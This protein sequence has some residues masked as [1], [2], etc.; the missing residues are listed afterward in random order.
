MP[1]FPD[2]HNLSPASARLC[3]CVER[4]L[5]TLG[6]KRG[7][8]L[9]AAVSGGSDSTAL[10]FVLCL[11]AQ[12]LDLRI[13]ALTVDHGLLPEAG[14]V[15][16]RV[17]A[18]CA[19]FG[20][21]CVSRKVDVLGL[22]GREHLGIEEAGRKLRYELLEDERAAREAEY[23]VLG[24]H[25]GDLAEDVLM[26]LTRGAGWPAL[27]GMKARDDRRRL[28]RPLLFV[29]PRDL[30]ALL[31]ECGLDWFEDPGNADLRF[32][33]NR[34]RHTVL[35]L[36]LKE[37]PSLDKKIGELWRLAQIDGDYWEE[38]L[39][40]LL[41]KHPWRMDAC[42]LTLPREL[43]RGRHPA[44]R[45]RLY[46]RALSI[47]SRVSITGRRRQARAD[48]LLA[49]DAAL[50]KGRGNARFQLPGG[51][52]AHLAGGAVVFYLKTAKG[53]DCHAHFAG[54]Q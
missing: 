13:F 51:V 27:G 53:M 6:L 54:S 25:S 24:H 48:T 47:F 35:P 2:I 11:L 34:L 52:E 43:L 40:E 42:C 46:H 1:F 9:L 44:V 10:V 49:L 26:R 5:L 14:A 36:L 3:L 7:T 33:R 39:D 45:L 16:A 23:S 50:A 12:R 28:L 15:A 29:K 4:F 30:E 19:E 37:N 20:I 18:Q 32:K 22:A 8:R 21:D 31:L 41:Q 17:S 38:I